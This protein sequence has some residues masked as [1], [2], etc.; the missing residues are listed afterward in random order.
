MQE[1]WKKVPIEPFS[2]YY[3]V[4]NLGRV[5]SLDRRLE[6]TVNGKKTT[7]FFHGKVLSPGL[8]GQG[9]PF[10][11]LNSKN[12]QTLRHVHRLVALAF[13][14]N[15]KP[16]EY[17]LVN[18]KDENPKN[19][20]AENLEW[21]TYSYNLTYGTAQERRTETRRK[22]IAEQKKNGTRKTWQ[23]STCKPFVGIKI[24]GSGKIE[25]R[26]LKDAKAAGYSI[27]Y[28]NQALKRK[29]LYDGSKTTNEYAGYKWFYKSELTKGKGEKENKRE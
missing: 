19:N 16:D 14:E 4:S 23:T 10:V 17:N 24:G 15:P 18:H 6:T 22:N 20:R 1:I 3:E 5:R 8:D 12:K 28:L 2:E 7:C 29:R 13:V 27:H 25:F 9:Y 21:C 11:S 26:T